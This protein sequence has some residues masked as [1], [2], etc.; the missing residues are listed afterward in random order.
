MKLINKVFKHAEQGFLIHVVTCNGAR[1]KTNKLGS[2][3]VVVFDR[4][5]LE[6]MINKGVFMDVSD[7][8]KN[9]TGA[10]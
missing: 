1:A 2:D 7:F 4:M 9:V 5:K 3:E 10:I 6:W 8:H